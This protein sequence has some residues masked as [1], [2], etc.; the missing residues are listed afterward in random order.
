MVCDQ[1]PDQVSTKPL[2]C[3]NLE[4]VKTNT[5]KTTD[6]QA[7]GY[8]I[9]DVGI[10]PE[11]ISSSMTCPECS[12]YRVILHEN[13]S[14]KQGLCSFL[15]IQCAS[16]G[17]EKKFRSSAP[18]G[19]SFDINRRMIYTIRN[20]GQGYSCIKKFTTFMNIPGPMTVKNFDHLMKFIAKKVED[21]AEDSTNKAAAELNLSS[22]SGGVIDTSVSCDGTWQRPS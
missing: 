1:P 17:Y 12:Q 15:F 16:C 14:K 13:F 18:A 7:D 22:E 2:N 4:N 5:P 9:I 20:L 21:V 10:L 3:S 8:R 6:R 19:K 11:F